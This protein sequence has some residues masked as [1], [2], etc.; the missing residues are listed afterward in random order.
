M[1]VCHLRR[2]LRRPALLCA[3]ALA[4]LIA[5]GGCTETVLTTEPVSISF[6]VSET[7]VDT[8][9]QFVQ[10]FNE[11]YPSITVEVESVRF[12][13]YGGFRRLEQADVFVFSQFAM[14]EFYDQKFILNLTP[15]IEQDPSFK[16]SDFYP[17][18]LSLFN[19][20]GKTWAIPA[21]VDTMVMY[22][23]Q[24]L[25]DRGGVSY[26]RVRWTWSDFL[27]AALA[28]RD[29]QAKVFGYVPNS[30]SMDALTFIYQHGGR[31][32]DDLENPTRSTFDDPLTIEALDWYAKLFFSYNVA[33]TREQMA[34]VFREGN[35]T[36]GIQDNQV[37]MWSGMLSERGG[38]TEGTRWTMRWGVVPLPRD[39][40]P[41][42]LTLIDGYYISARTQYPDACWRWVSFLTRQ[43]PSRQ[44]PPRRSLVESADY[45]AKVGDDVVA[46]ITASMENALLL[47]PTLSQYEEVL[48]AFG[49][50]FE[51]IMTQR[52]T[53]EDAMTA[54]QQESSLK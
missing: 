4:L 1:P 35:A 13:R 53:P 34:E 44:T 40:E 42:A 22:Y 2:V 32:L 50:A 11:R 18:T 7:D 46:A 19:R 41:A 3:L 9:R 8:Y 39:R 36:Y 16:A 33:P 28:L 21:A 5:V 25:F 30:D 37:A 14:S 26:P 38:R 15:F 52:S 12:D 6:A 24:D 20:D 10:A 47:S 48:T 17:G 54:A 27:S 23:N 31:I 51:A 29:P 43:M 49:T 45:R